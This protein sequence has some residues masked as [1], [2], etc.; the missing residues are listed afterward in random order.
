M[1]VDNLANFR[2]VRASAHK[3]VTDAIVRALES[4][5][6]RATGWGIEDAYGPLV[7]KFARAS[8]AA[9]F[10]FPF[11]KHRDLFMV[12][13]GTHRIPLNAAD[14]LATRGRRVAWAF[15]V[16]PNSY[17]AMAENLRKYKIDVLFV[18]AKQS[19]DRLERAVTG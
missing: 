6:G 12:M 17:D 14:W 15:D 10:P 3:H 18:T 5:I 4:E 13:M 8:V 19:A 2:I 1:A 9:N 16:W 11:K 7:Q